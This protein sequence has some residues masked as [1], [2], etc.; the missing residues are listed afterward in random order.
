VV[1]SSA[2][3]CGS[4]PQQDE[5]HRKLN[6]VFGNNEAGNGTGTAERTRTR[7]NT[8]PYDTKANSAG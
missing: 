8:I 2:S 3:R 6:W 1:G 5:Q 4:A 7:T